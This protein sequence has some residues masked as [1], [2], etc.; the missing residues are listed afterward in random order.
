MLILVNKILA[1]D[2]FVANLKVTIKALQEKF[3]MFTYLTL[4]KIGIAIRFNEIV[5]LRT[6]IPRESLGEIPLFPQF[7][8]IP[9]LLLSVLSFLLASSLLM[10]SSS[11][12]SGGGS[13]LQ[14]KN[15]CKISDFYLASQRFGLQ[16]LNSLTVCEQIQ[17]YQFLL[18]FAN[19]LSFYI[20][21]FR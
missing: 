14:I 5:L 12:F 1:I 2:N 18:A 20:H 9:A 13:S 19:T 15:V 3:I 7:R 16:E 10:I 21:R 8:G 17:V 11:P 6:G 4:I